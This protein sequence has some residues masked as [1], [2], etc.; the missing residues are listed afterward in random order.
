MKKLQTSSRKGFTII[1]VV[2]VLAIGGL[3]MLMV[4]IALPALQRNQRD[5]QRQNDVQRIQSAVLNFQSSNRGAVPKPLTGDIDYVRG[6]MKKQVTGE[7]YK[8]SGTWGYFYDNYVLVGSAGQIDAFTDPDGSPYG[9]IVQ[10]CFGSGSRPNAGDECPNGQ[11]HLTNFDDQSNGTSA[12]GGAKLST[13]D[14]AY[15]TEA[16]DNG[17]TISI[18]TNATCDNDRAVYSSGSRKLAFL[19][20]KEG[21]GAICVGL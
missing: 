15:G 20:K 16:G 21:G 10:P 14:D 3:I 1:E 13:A 11:R 17:H 19:Y 7:G 12:D 4:L 8:K 2:L 9:L 18:V 5:S 6:H